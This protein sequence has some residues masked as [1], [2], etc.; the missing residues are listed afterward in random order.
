MA[1]YLP[2]KKSW[3]REKLIFHYRF[4]NGPSMQY[5]RQLR[6][7]WDKHYGQVHPHLKDVQLTVGSRI[8][9]SLE[10]RLVNKKPPRTF[11][12]N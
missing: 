10:Y 12:V 2:I 11:L 3:N 8:N 7:L 5:R 6:R 9:P 4:E 1:E